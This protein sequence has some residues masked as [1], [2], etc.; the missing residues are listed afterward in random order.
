MYTWQI[1]KHAL[2]SAT[3]FKDHEYYIVDVSLVARSTT[4]I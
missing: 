4:G 2:F 1:S 3:N